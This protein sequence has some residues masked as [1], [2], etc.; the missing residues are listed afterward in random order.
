MQANLINFTV[1]LGLFV[2]NS[3][4]KLKFLIFACFADGNVS[5][6]AIAMALSGFTKEKNAL[7][8]EMCSSLCQNL[9]NPYLRAMFGF[10]TTCDNS[11]D[12]VLVSI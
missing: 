11:Y 6:N 9:K 12:A 7:W 8:C 4:Y 10:L 2:H 1:N 5:L 3:L